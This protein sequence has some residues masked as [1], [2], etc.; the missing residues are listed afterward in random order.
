MNLLTSP[1]LIYF[2]FFGYIIDNIVNR[3]RQPVLFS[4]ALDKPP[5]HKIYKEPRIKLFKKRINLFCLI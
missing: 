4:F 2:I 3:I 1:D 5:G